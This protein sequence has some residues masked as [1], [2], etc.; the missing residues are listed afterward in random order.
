MRSY[1][2]LFAAILC[3]FLSCQK[4]PDASL[5]TASACKLDKIYSYDLSGS[6]DTSSFEYTADK[7]SRINH[8]DYY[9]DL[10]YSGTRL[11]KRNILE[12]ANNSIAGFDEFEYN[13]DSTI[14]RITYYDVLVFLPQP[15]I[16]YQ[17]DFSYNAGRLSYALSK[18]FDENTGG[19]ALYHESFFSYTGNN[20]SQV[21]FHSFDGQSTDTL[22]YS[23]DAKQNYYG[24]QPNLWLTDPLFINYEGYWL[25]MALSAN[26]VTAITDTRAY[27]VAIDYDETDK[28]DIAALRID[29]DLWARYNYKCQ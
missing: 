4:E 12:K 3:C 22:H 7:V 8:S 20:I 21:I 27:T 11:V 18:N 19:L 28:Q 6:V 26:N 2:V 14:S 23:F 24:K 1:H 9:E 10:E 29:G 25:P 13:P 5:L 17:T 15:L 16:V